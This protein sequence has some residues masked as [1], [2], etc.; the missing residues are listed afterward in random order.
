MTTQGNATAAADA[1]DNN[2][3]NDNNDAT[4]ISKKEESDVYDR[5]IRLWGADAQVCMCHSYLV[6][7]PSFFFCVHSPQTSSLAY[8]PS[9]AKS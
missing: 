2:N 3:D 4:S 5:Q 7:S 6:S 9:T 1:V 8:H